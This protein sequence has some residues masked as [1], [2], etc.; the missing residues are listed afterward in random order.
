MITSPYLTTSDK[1]IIELYSASGI[2]LIILCP[3]GVLY[4]NQT[5]GHA[6]LHPVAEGVYVPLINSDPQVHQE[7]ELFEYFTG[8]KYQGWCHDGIDE[9]DL[10]VIDHILQKGWYT[11]YLLVDRDRLRASHEAWIYV[12]I[13]KHPDRQ[14]HWERQAGYVL[15][16]FEGKNG[17]LTWTNSD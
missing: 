14:A 16:G 8:S 4:T 12:T 11:K 6:C 10:A 17:I 15:Y 7:T 9:D 2:G 1:P 13:Q 3:S 5:G